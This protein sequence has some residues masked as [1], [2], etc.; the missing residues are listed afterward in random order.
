MVYRSVLLL[1]L[2]PLL[3]A[4][5][6]SDTRAVL[7]P[8]VRLVVGSTAPS[9]ISCTSPNNSMIKIFDC[10]ETP[11]SAVKLV[12]RAIYIDYCLT[13]NLSLLARDNLFTLHNIRCTALVRSEKSV[14]HQQ[15]HRQ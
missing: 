15:L 7:V 3:L 6:V 13:C 11:V 2:L 10:A 5:I 1:L 4:S 9:T 12:I 8:P 14:L